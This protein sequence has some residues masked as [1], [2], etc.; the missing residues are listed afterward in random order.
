MPKFTDKKEL[1]MPLR[2]SDLLSQNSAE[3]TEA[4]QKRNTAFSSVRNAF[5]TASP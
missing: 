2:P 4:D 3:K 1:E 5:S